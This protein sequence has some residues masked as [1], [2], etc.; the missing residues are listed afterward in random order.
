MSEELEVG[1]SRTYEIG[2]RTLKL[3]PLSLGK[4]KRATTI[5][6]E[7]GGDDMDLI[8]R[9]VLA[10][11]ENDENK[12]LSLEWIVENI[13]LPLAHDI[14]LDSRRVNGLGQ[15]FQTGPTPVVAKVERPLEETPVVEETKEI[16]SV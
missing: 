8:A 13:T 16:P 11:L 10:V 4:M 12:D 3:K 15:S 5:F 9:Y 6:T 7:K 1:G 14:V 2:G